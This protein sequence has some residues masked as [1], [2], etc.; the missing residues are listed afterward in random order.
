MNWA[1]YVLGFLKIPFSEPLFCF[2]TLNFPGAN[3]SQIISVEVLA[4]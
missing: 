3:L 2:L 1:K 4:D